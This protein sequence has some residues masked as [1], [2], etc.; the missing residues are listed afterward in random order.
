MKLWIDDIRNAPDDSWTVVRNVTSAIKAIA[1][2][3]DSIEAISFD[4]DISYQI[5]MGE[6][7]RPYPS[8]ETFQAV[9]EYVVLYYMK[10]KRILPL[11]KIHTANPTGAIALEKILKD[12][13][14]VTNMLGVAKRL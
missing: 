13:R 14:P 8:P 7:S 2:F 12:F 11:I 6:V 10:E 9:A 3:G 5:Q 1:M 4:H